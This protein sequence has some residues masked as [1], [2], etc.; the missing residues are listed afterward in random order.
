MLSFDGWNLVGVSRL[1]GMLIAFLL[2]G[3]WQQLENFFALALIRSNF[4]KTTYDISLD[5]QI[6]FLPL[7]F[8]PLT[9]TPP[10]QREREVETG[11]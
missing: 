7:G 9:T 3:C 5:S 1:M 11:G 4:I 8:S 2:C 6:Y 10:H